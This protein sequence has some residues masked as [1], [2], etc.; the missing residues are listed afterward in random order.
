MLNVR[1]KF[2]YRK[3]FFVLHKTGMHVELVLL[4]PSHA[5]LNF[6][7][8]KQIGVNFRVNWR[9]SPLKLSQQ[10]Q[11][12]TFYSTFSQS[13]SVFLLRRS[14]FSMNNVEF[15]LIMQKWFFLEEKHAK[16]L[17]AGRNDI[18]DGIMTEK[19][20]RVWSVSRSERVYQHF[21]ESTFLFS[22]TT[23]TRNARKSA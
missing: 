2:N 15:S 14:K 4:K 22:S 9:H 7:S 12:G 16:R 5:S 19:Y 1:T 20:V 18:C 8:A 6:L 17:C 23:T 10:P 21:Y 13:F 3:I 11:L